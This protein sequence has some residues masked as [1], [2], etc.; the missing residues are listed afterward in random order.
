MLA[1]NFTSISCSRLRISCRYQARAVAFA[2]SLYITICPARLSELPCRFGR[3]RCTRWP[4]RHLHDWADM[5]AL[6]CTPTARPLPDAIRRITI[7]RYDFG[8]RFALFQISPHKFHFRINELRAFH[9]L[10]MKNAYYVDMRAIKRKIKRADHA[11][12]YF[13]HFFI[14]SKCWR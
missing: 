4:P 10:A 9:A 3:S 14:L 2:Y 6:I 12:C 8:F 7:F 5:R 1:H 11:I 13:I